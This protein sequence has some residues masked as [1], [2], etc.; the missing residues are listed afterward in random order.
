MVPFR[1][2]ARHSVLRPFASVGSLEADVAS[3]ENH[4]PGVSVPNNI[5]RW[6]NSSTCNCFS[7]M[8]IADLMHVVLS[9][10]S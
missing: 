5:Q 9:W 10:T 1:A 4:A 3:Q 2:I 8:N 6:D 7:S